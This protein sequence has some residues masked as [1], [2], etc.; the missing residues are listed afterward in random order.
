M[1]RLFF[2]SQYDIQMWERVGS[3][4]TCTL[5]RFDVPKLDAVGLGL[6]PVDSALLVGNVNSPLA[7]RTRRRRHLRVAIGCRRA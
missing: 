5:G 6:F 4:S 7:Q 3:C 1:L 2:R